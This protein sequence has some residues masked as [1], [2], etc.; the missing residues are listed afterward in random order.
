MR[1]L[2]IPRRLTKGLL[3]VL[4]LAAGVLTAYALPG[5]I[6]AGE[7][8]TSTLPSTPTTTPASPGGATTASHPGSTWLYV[9][10][11][12]GLVLLLV[13][14]YVIDLR[15]TQKRQKE[16][17]GYAKDDSGFLNAREL[18]Q[19]VDRATSGSEG[20]VRTLITFGVMS[21]FAAALLYLLIKNPT[22]KHTT[23]V[24]N[25]ISAL[26]TLLTA[27]VA[28]Y[29]GTR[30]TQTTAKDKEDKEAREEKKE[31]KEKEAKEK[32]AKEK[33]AKEKEAKEKEAKEKEAK[34]KE[35]KEKE[36]KEKE[37][38]EKEQPHDPEA[39]T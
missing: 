10:L 22:I 19:V 23:I 29:F 36:A 18:N 35:A 25:A 27:I 8:A 1:P 26:I 28:F 16:L 17:I 13:I 24:S 11:L 34:E 2:H 33:E 9:V 39:P 32:E 31:A 4:V 15:Q 21:I 38:K 7:L 37:A 30:S 3:F 14:P 6:K 5:A 20:L 12:L